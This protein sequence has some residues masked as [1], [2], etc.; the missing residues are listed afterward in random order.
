M[1]HRTYLVILTQPAL[2]RGL[3]QARGFARKVP[4]VP[5]AYV[6]VSQLGAETDSHSLYRKRRQCVHDRG[7]RRSFIWLGVLGMDMVIPWVVFG[8]ERLLANFICGV[9]HHGA[10]SKDIQLMR[11]TLLVKIPDGASRRLDLGP[12]RTLGL[13]L[14]HPRLPAIPSILPP[15]TTTPILLHQP[16]KSP[17]QAVTPSSRARRN[18]D[19]LCL[20]RLSYR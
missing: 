8:F 17:P 16:P 6:S 5:P 4:H 13:A 18:D 9:Y 20:R 2:H 19:H 14:V 7:M 15:H 10:Y 1:L 11:M 3:A 12:G